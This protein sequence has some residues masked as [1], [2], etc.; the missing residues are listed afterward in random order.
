MNKEE[1]VKL[2]NEILKRLT[3]EGHLFDDDLRKRAEKFLKDTE[4]LLK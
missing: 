2:R 3:F 4:E 1:I